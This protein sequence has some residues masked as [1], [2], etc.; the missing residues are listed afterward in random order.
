MSMP[1]PV[2]QRPTNSSLAIWSLICGILT[3]ICLG[4]LAGIAAIICGHMALSQIK[5]A[6][7]TLGGGGMAITGLVLGYL[8]T[9]I[10]GVVLVAAL[11]FPMI[12]ASKE[13]ARRAKAMQDVHSIVQAVEQFQTEYNQYP[14]VG[15]DG[16]HDVTVAENNDRLFNI[17]RAIDPNHAGNPKQQVFFDGPQATPGGK[18]KGGFGPNGVFYDPWG[19]PYLIRMDRSGDGQ[20]ENPYGG[21]PADTVR[22]GVIAW[23]L[24]RDALPGKNGQGDVLSWPASPR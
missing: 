3:W 6:P 5:R 13:E 15:G 24:G 4:P 10:T 16:T 12:A 8:G 7:G 11:V 9:V 23:S 1:P 2:F 20:V 17:L 19:N 22:A 14:D 18:A 21:S